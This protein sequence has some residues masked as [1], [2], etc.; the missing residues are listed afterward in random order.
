[1]VLVVL[2][3][4]VRVEGRSL[5]GGDGLAGGRSDCGHQQAGTSVC[6]RAMCVSLAS[7]R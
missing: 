4:M 1:M 6:G 7:I 2:V 5:A 3:A